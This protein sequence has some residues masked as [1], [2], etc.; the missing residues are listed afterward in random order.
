[1]KLKTNSLNNL[2]EYN[3]EVFMQPIWSGNT[4]Y[5]EAVMFADT[6][7]GYVQKFKKL[8]YPID[9]IICVRNNNLYLYEKLASGK[10]VNFLVYGAS[11]ATGCS[12]TGANANY[13]LFG[14]VADPQGNYT[15][16][17]KAMDTALMHP[18]FSNKP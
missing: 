9:E 16:T 11:T 1:M 12:S 2:S 6:A 3:S 18:H 13:E 17:K 8:L 10:D 5:H 14:K 4:V 7:D 15:V